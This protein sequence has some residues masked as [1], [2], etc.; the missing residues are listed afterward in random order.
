MRRMIS[1]VDLATGWV[2][3]LPSD[4][5]TFDVP[6]DFAQETWVAAVDAR[7]HAHYSSARGTTVSSAVFP[8]PLSWRV[9]GEECLVAIGAR[10]ATHPSDYKLCAVEP[11]HR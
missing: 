9:R 3:D 10:A 2:S 7:L 1:I 5:P 6:Q 8:R 11:D 4:T